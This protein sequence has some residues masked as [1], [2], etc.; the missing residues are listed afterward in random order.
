MTLRYAKPWT[1]GL[2]SPRH[3]RPGRVAL[4]AAQTP[5]PGSHAQ[6]PRDAAQ[7][8][9]RGNASTTRQHREPEP[10]RDRTDALRAAGPASPAPSPTLRL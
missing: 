8:P 10:G 1:P 7:S 3:S 2:R 4:R 5:A 9:A 6:S